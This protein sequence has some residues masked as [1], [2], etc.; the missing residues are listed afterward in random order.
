MKKNNQ[1][2]GN[3]SPD[4]KENNTLSRKNFLQK[5]AATPLVIAGV[6]AASSIE[7][8]QNDKDSRDFLG[9]LYDSTKCRGCR[10]CVGNCIK[11]ND[12]KN[13]DSENWKKRDTDG[14]TRTSIRLFEHDNKEYDFIKAGCNHCLHPSC[15]SACPVTAMMKDEETGI[16]FNDPDKCIGCRYCM[17]ACPFD[18]VK[19]EWDDTFPKVIKCDL[20]INSNLSETGPGIPG[21]VDACPSDALMFGT[22]EE[23]LEEAKKRIAESPEKY[24]PKVY[25]EKD[26]GGTSILYLADTEFENLG[27]PK[28]LG[29]ESPAVLS[30]KLQSTYKGLVAPIVGYGMLAYVVYQNYMLQNDDDKKEDK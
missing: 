17:I 6:G 27:F 28:D 23:L 15:V 8:S 20:C 3:A 18:V 19:F 5:A 1:N 12:M 21:C 2:K 4:M 9:Y 11:V 26:G 10:A 7:A 16:V 24:N 22:R 13:L 14:Y 25:G 30:E 29:D